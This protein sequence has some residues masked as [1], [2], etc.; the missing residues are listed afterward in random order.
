MSEYRVIIAGGSSQEDCPP[1]TYCH[2]PL[3]RE[4]TIADGRYADCVLDHS[5]VTGAVAAYALRDHLDRYVGRGRV[6]YTV[7]GRPDGVTWADI[8]RSYAGTAPFSPSVDDDDE[9]DGD[10]PWCEHCHESGH[11]SEEHEFF[12]CDDCGWGCEVPDCEDCLMWSEEAYAN[13][14]EDCYARHEHDHGSEPGLS[15]RNH[16]CCGTDDVH[17]DEVTERFVCDCEARRLIADK[18]P[19][20]LAY[21]LPT[22]EA[23]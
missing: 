7:V 4:Q 23:D 20:L 8:A 21:E 14:C 6:T 12:Y 9:E 10:E 17:H 15:V 2:A 19:V 22:L 3:L 11:E 18:R 5:T 1:G 16:S 13:V